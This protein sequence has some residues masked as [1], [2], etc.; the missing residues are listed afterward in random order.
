MAGHPHIVS[1]PDV[2]A[3]SA[4]VIRPIVDVNHDSARAVVG[5]AVARIAG[6]TVTRGTVISAARIIRSISRAVVISTTGD[7]E[8]HRDEE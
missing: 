8:S 6:V 1:A 3:C 2:V 4:C 5:I 7:Q